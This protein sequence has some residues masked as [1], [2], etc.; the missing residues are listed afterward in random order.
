MT[1]KSESTFGTGEEFKLT[2]S[3]GSIQ[4]DFKRP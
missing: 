2:I 3:V 1:V 4:G